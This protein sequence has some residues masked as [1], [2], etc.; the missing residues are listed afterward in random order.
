MTMILRNIITWIVSCVCITL[1]VLAVTFTAFP[2]EDWTILLEHKIYDVPFWGI[3]IGFPV[4]FGLVIGASRGLYW[5]QRLLRIDRQLN[6]VIKGQR[7]IEDEE[8]LK[9]IQF[10]EDSIAQIQDKFDEQIER[11]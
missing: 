6:Q 8:Q 1:F 9:E 5:R 2:L 3:I 11:A 10:I 7:L 4:M